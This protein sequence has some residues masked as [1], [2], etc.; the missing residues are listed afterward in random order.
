MDVSWVAVL[1][2]V[3]II[4]RDFM[5]FVR[6]DALVRV[7]VNALM[8]GDRGGWVVVCISWGGMRNCLER[9]FGKGV[10]G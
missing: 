1:E 8:I 2:V 5:A 4:E 3:D 6:V 7:K 10:V 9:L